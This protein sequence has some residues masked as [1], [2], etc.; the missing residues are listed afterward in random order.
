MPKEAL[1]RPHIPTPTPHPHPRGT[2]TTAGRVAQGLAAKGRG[3][4]GGGSLTAGF[5]LAVD[6]GHPE[7][8]RA[9]VEHHSEL[10]GRGPDFDLPEVL[11]LR[12][13]GTGSGTWGTVGG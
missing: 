8:R 13:D 7:V 11:T 9:G 12:T 6:R 10:L 3:V 4:G 1:L 5:T 2:P